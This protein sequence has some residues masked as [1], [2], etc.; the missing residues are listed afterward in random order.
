MEKSG[1]MLFHYV[2][3]PTKVVMFIEKDPR[4]KQVRPHPDL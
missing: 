1:K 2:F 3:D 4:S